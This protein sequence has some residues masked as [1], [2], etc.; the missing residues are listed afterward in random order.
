MFLAMGYLR[1]Q[2]FASTL[3][4]EL[5]FLRIRGNGKYR[6]TDNTKTGSKRETFTEKN[7]ISPDEKHTGKLN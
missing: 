5:V 6:N 2:I 7:K 4:I 3:Y 1:L